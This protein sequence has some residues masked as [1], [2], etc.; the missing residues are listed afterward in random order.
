MLLIF[1]MVP[2]ALPSAS[3]SHAGGLGS[4]V[5]ELGSRTTRVDGARSYSDKKFKTIASL[6]KI[7]ALCGGS[8]GLGVF[9]GAL[10]RE[11][12]P[13]K[14]NLSNDLILLVA[15]GTYI[16]SKRNCLSAK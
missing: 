3:I 15:Q 13:W 4:Q 1:T 6:G 7:S 9:V 14:K 10:V 16:E 2:Y 5:V 11:F 8:V 12:N